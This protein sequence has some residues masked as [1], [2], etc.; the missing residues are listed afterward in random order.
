MFFDKGYNIQGI[1]QKPL[2]Q[3]CVACVPVT[4]LQADNW[5]PLH[6]FVTDTKRGAG[7]TFSRT[8][9]IISI[10]KGFLQKLKYMCYRFHSLGRKRQHSG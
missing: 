1:F 6:V 9:G 10:S 8:P 5:L 7:Y 4:S 2:W 3:I